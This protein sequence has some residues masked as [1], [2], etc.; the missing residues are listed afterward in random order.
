MSSAEPR[1]AEDGAESMANND[2]A[3]ALEHKARGN[4]LYKTQ[5]YSEAIEEYNKAIDM[6]PSNS[7]F[8]GNR[9]AAHMMQ[10]QYEEV[11]ADCKKAVELDEQFVKAYLRGGKAFACLVR[12]PRA[13]PPGPGRRGLKHPFREALRLAPRRAGRCGGRQGLSDPGPDP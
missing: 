11:I 12:R 1:P 8:Y 6:D 10:K 2:A 3:A 5:R 9:S 13:A 7:R 4:E